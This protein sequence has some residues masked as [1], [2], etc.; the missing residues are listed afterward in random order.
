MPKSPDSPDRL[1]FVKEGISLV[2]HPE[3]LEVQITDYHARPVTVP[4]QTLMELRRRA[5]PL[6]AEEPRGA[7][8][9][10]TEVES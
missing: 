2:A 8:T 10:K 1:D 4:W 3:G 5:I 7:A 9:R 6:E